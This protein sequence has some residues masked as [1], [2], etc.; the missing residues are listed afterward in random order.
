MWILVHTTRDITSP[1]TLSTAV[2]PAE[3]EGCQEHEYECS[4]GSCILLH[5][6][7][8]GTADC[9][10]GNDEADC[11]YNGLYISNFLD[12]NFRKGIICA[13]PANGICF[14]LRRTLY[15]SRI[16]AICSYPTTEPVMT[17]QSSIK[18][19][20]IIF[21]QNSPVSIKVIIPYLN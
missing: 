12:A 2:E 20:L 16:S 15:V 19:V 10:D 5:W 21:N 3:T 11:Q 7:C 18:E 8:D 9:D 13:T 17:W 14:V 1:I 4:D 6:L